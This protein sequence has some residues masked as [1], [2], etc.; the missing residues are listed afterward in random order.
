MET[1]KK[2]GTKNS[3]DTTTIMDLDQGVPTSLPTWVV[4]NKSGPG[5]LWMGRQQFECSLG[6]NISSMAESETIELL[7]I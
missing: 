5:G 7:F 6:G 1:L 4:T 3:D 2:T